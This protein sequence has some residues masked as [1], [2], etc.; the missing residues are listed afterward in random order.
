ML[1]LKGKIPRKIMVRE[2]PFNLKE[3][4]RGYGILLK[5]IF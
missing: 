2:R 4:G 5:N 3:G 1:C